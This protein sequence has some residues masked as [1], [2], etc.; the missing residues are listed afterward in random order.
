MDLPVPPSRA[1]NEIAA[2][3]FLYTRDG[4]FGYQNLTADLPDDAREKRM[5]PVDEASGLLGALPDLTAVAAGPRGLRR[6]L[7]SER[8]KQL[9]H[10]PAAAFAGPSSSPRRPCAR[11]A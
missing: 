9:P 11:G 6:V 4:D 8:K 10:D 1:A 7:M 3:V 5:D 2:D